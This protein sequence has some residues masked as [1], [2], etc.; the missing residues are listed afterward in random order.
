MVDLPRPAG[1]GL[2]PDRFAADQA[3]LD[4]AGPQ[5]PTGGRFVHQDPVDEHLEAIAIVAA[6]D[7]VPAGRADPGERGLHLRH[8]RRVAR[9]QLEADG[10][11]AGEE[12]VDQGRS[13]SAVLAEEGLTPP[14][15]GVPQA[16]ADRERQT[17]RGSGRRRSPVRRRDTRRRAWPPGHRRRSRA[18]RA[19]PGPPVARRASPRRRHAACSSPPGLRARTCPRPR[20]RPGRPRRAAAAPRPRPG[21]PRASIRPG[22][23]RHARSCYGPSGA[24]AD[25]ARRPGSEPRPVC[26]R[27]RGLTWPRPGDGR[28]ARRPPG[29]PRP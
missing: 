7:V 23:G 19:A 4:V 25:H 15:R 24:R 12:V 28:R 1:L 14:P 2:A 20:R 21:S 22:P 6:D 18:S 10:L 16:D 29:S 13:S 11:L 5:G 9:P 17:R 27:S 8:P 26:D 3:G